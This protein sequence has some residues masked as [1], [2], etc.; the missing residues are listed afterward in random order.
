[1]G[2]S[3]TPVAF[4]TL[5]TGGLMITIIVTIYL[6]IALILNTLSIIGEKKGMEVDEHMVPLTWLQHFYFSITWPLK[7]Y[8]LYKDSKSNEEE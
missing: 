6:L 2:S 3:T 4:R 8:L 1:M 7:I 5:C